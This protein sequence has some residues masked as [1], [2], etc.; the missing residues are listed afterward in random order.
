ML[1]LKRLSNKYVSNIEIYISKNEKFQWKYYACRTSSTA[2]MI[3]VGSL[4]FTIN[5]LSS[6]GEIMLQIEKKI[7]NIENDILNFPFPVQFSEGLNINDIDL[8][9]YIERKL[10][11]EPKEDIMLKELLRKLDTEIMKIFEKFCRLV[12]IQYHIS[13]DSSKIV[14][15]GNHIGKRE[16]SI[17]IQFG[18]SQTGRHFTDLSI[19]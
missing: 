1:A 3:F 14:E 9:K 17:Y 10:N 13:A 2:F 8:A 7:K 15:Q 18:Q 4:N 11:N 12:K 16:T 5:E 6:N 19:C